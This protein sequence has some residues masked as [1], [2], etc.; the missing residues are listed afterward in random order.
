MGEHEFAAD[1]QRLAVLVFEIY[2]GAGAHVAEVL[3][4]E[5]DFKDVVVGSRK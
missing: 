4:V 1:F 3:V 5:F 2:H